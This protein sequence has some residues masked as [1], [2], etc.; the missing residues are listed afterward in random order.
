MDLESWA[1][2]WDYTKAYDAMIRATDTDT[3]PWYRVKADDKR[4]ARLSCI[5][6]LLG[7]IPYG[8]IPFELARLPKRRKRRK[9][10][11]DILPFSHA[12]PEI[13]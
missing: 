10:I 13:Y 12:V 4:L 6:H 1:R 11:P 7:T 2:W 5:S 8:E 3:A 9:G